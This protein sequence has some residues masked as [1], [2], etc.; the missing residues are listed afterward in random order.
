S[1]TSPDVGDPNRSNN[2]A[3]VNSTVQ[4]RVDVTVSKS[5]TPNPVRVGEPLVYVITARNNGPSTA[6][7]VTI[8]DALPANTAMLGTAT[9]TNAGTCT[10]PADGAISG[11][12]AC[13]W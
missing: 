8:T 2:S 12:V 13:S 11:S 1:V 5:V 10:A 9:A 6:T 3:S 4:P 7:N